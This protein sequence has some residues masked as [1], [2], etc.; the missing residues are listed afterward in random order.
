MDFI[1]QLFHPSFLV[2][3]VWILLHNVARVF[4]FLWFIRQFP[5]NFYHAIFSTSVEWQKMGHLEG[6][7]DS[8]PRKL[9]QN[10]LVE[11]GQV[12]YSIFWTPNKLVVVRVL[13]LFVRINWGHW[14][15]I[16]EKKNE[17]NFFNMLSIFI[18]ILDLRAF[19]LLPRYF[20]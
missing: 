5:V 20:I 4:R 9:K 6:H 12:H 13:N 19:V 14:T 7:I 16:I 10:S 18:P 3:A 2:G 15:W 17:G 11:L 8:K 1:Y